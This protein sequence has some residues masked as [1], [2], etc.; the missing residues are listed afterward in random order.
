MGNLAGW[1]Q[2]WW[3]AHVRRFFLFLAILPVTMLRHMFTSPLNMYLRDKE[4][5]KGAMKPMPNLMETELESFGASTIE[6]FTWKQLLDTDA[7]TMCGRC[8]S[9][10]PAH[11]TGKP[12][13]PREIVLKTGEVM[14]AT[15]APQVSPPIGIDP[16]ITI[17][18]DS[19]FERITPEEVW[20]CT[21]CKACDEICPVN[22]EIL[23]KILDMR[24]YLSLMESNFPT[25]LGNAYR[26][27]GELRQPVGHDAR[28][29]GP[30]GP[31]SSTTSRSSS[32]ATRFDHEYLYWVGCAGSFDD[33]NQK[34]TQAMAKLLQRA[35]IDF[36]ILGP[37]ENC[38]GDPARRS[39]NEYIF[40]MLAMQNIET[41]NGMGVKKIITQCPHCFNTLSNEY[42][43]LGGNYEVI[44]HSQLLENLI[45]EGKLDLSRGPA[46]RAD[47]LPR[48]LLPR[49]PQR[50]VP[51]APQGHRPAWAASRSSRPAA[52]APR[53]C[54]AAPAAPACGWRRRSARRST[55]S[56]PRS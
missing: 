43:Q 10:C 7:C 47:R 22:I 2:A 12:L 29:T 24:R 31:R 8:T 20:A 35:G 1:H 52:T 21:S 40:Q 39:G 27:D 14:A 54:A 19:L 44:H 56:A 5:P 45:D 13:D 6:D 25:E 17:G 18:A 23:D 46:R 36:A 11:A 16:E 38:T 33:K 4:R 15:G 53:A 55:T 51:G 42:P 49:P 34:V 28:P 30:S 9:V 32:R 26:V 41:L 3:I 50:R 37:S 48:L